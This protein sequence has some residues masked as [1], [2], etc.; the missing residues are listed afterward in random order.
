MA[1][2]R[3]IDP[4][5]WRDS[6]VIKLSNDE[7]IVWIGCISSADDEGIIEPDPDSLF[8]EMGRRELT[9]EKIASALD[10]LA[11]L[12]MIIRYGRYAFLPNWFKHQTLNRPTRTKM[13][14]PPRSIVEKYPSY[15]AAWEETFSFWQG[16]GDAREFIEVAY[17]IREDDIEDSEPETDPQE[18][19]LPLTDNSVSAHQQFTPNRIE[20]KGKEE[21]RREE[22]TS[23]RDKPASHPPEKI[24][25]VYH[26]IKATYESQWDNETLPNYAREGPALKKFTQEA[27]KR[28]PDDPD[29]W[30]R[31][32]CETH[33]RLK[34][35]RESL[36]SGH[37]FLPSIAMSGGLFPRLIEEMQSGKAKLSDRDR[38]K[39]EALGA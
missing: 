16:K 4:G 15:I 30:A 39:L 21:K 38:R 6:N 9:S 32:A 2:K 37:P 28:S 8:F 36:F 25:P 24:H 27:L 31:Q 5:I 7:F 35:D 33:L 19:E 13:I 34:N 29:T 14:R 17:P 23:T 10:R 12:E 20:E 3:M 11:K 26:S 1:R 22:N 18:N